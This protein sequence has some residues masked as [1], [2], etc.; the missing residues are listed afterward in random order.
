MPD[1]ENQ[2]K[3]LPDLEHA[4]P[5]HRIPTIIARRSLAV[6]G[7]GTWSRIFGLIHKLGSEEDD[8]P[9]SRIRY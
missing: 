9:V 7:R 5:A 8:G 6:S 3:Q 2:D 4:V 1:V